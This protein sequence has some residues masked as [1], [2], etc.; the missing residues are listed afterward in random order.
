MGRNTSIPPGRLLE[1]EENKVKALKNTDYEGIN[2][3][4][5][6]HFD[7]GKQLEILTANKHENG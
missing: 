6:K 5:V 3:G 1:E 4:R 2:S 7:V